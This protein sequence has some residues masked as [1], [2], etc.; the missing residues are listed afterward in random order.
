MS[1]VG[2]QIEGLREIVTTL[3]KGEEELEKFIKARKHLVKVLSPLKKSKSFTIQW[4]FTQ[5]QQEVS[6]LELALLHRENAIK[7]FGDVL[8][9]LEEREERKKDDKD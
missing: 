1:S 5:L 2:R 4:A 3:R 6:S 7:W 8:M 9:A